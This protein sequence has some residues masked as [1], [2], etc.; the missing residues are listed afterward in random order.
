MQSLFAWL[1]SHGS[2]QNN[3]N[4]QNK[5]SDTVRTGWLT[6]TM[7]QNDARFVFFKNTFI[8]YIFRKRFLKLARAITALQRRA[9]LRRLRGLSDGRHHDTMRWALKYRSSLL[10]ELNRIDSIIHKGE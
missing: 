5:K 4:N 1:L 7:A 10:C 2:N 3:Q 8:A 9:K 6:E